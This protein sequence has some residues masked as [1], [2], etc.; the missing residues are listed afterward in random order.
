MLPTDLEFFYYWKRSYQRECQD[1]ELT[2][3][4]DERREIEEEQWSEM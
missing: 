4:A 3:L 2:D 1:E